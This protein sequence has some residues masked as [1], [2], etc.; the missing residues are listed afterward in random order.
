MDGI[1][2]LRGYV[3]SRFGGKNVAKTAELRMT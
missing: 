3:D 1:C 2:V